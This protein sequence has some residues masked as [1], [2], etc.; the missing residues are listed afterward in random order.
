MRQ[1]R[2]RRD[3]QVQAH[4]D[5]RRVHERAV[6]LVHLAARVDQ[7]KTLAGL[8]QFLGPGVL[9]Q[10]DEADPGNLRQGGELLQGNVAGKPRARPAP[11]LPVDSDL[12]ALHVAELPPPGLDQRR[13]GGRIGHGGRDRLQPR[14]KNLGQA[15][16][17][18]LGAECRKL[19][20]LTDQLI[21]TRTSR[22]QRQQPL[23]A[24][25]DHGSAQAFD[26]RSVADELDG[27]AQPLLGMEQDGPA[28]QRPPVPER[29]GKAARPHLF[30]FPAHWY[31][32]QP[33]AK[34][35]V[36]SQRKA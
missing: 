3:H 25:Q 13:G 29:L 27:V 36:S 16:Q 31:S 19:V 14:A 12:V 28:L 20:S 35:A 22:Q 30:G 2:V 33:R 21:N 4:H 5:R 11:P 18:R 17:R 6:G 23:R 15:Q 26:Q 32:D 7:R 34:S 9:L 10:A 8:R 1:G 24:F